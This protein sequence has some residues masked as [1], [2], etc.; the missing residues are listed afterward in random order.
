MHLTQLEIHLD[1]VWDFNPFQNPAIE[2]ELH[3]LVKFLNSLSW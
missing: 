3:H 2:G 1:K